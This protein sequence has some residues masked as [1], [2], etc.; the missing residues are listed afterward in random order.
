M[1]V[2]ASPAAL[3]LSANLKERQKLLCVRSTKQFNLN[4]NLIIK[5]KIKFK[6]KFKIKLKLKLKLKEKL[7]IILK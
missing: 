2:G 3:Q 1:D 5:I 4:F 7:K 6:I